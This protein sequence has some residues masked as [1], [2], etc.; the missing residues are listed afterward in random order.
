MFKKL[1]ANAIYV[2]YFF[3]KNLTDSGA[4]HTTSSSS[5][6][7]VEAEDSDSEMDRIRKYFT[8]KLSFLRPHEDEGTSEKILSEPSLDGIINFINDHKVTK[9]LTQIN[10][11]V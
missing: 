8:D 2:V 3:S 9:I 7:Q 1:I 10:N 5:L 6:D 4:E 11:E